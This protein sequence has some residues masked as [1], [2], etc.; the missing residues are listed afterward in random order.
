MAVRTAHLT[1]FNLLLRLCS[2]LG[3]TDIQMFVSP[4]MIKVKSTRVAKSTINAADRC[5]IF[6]EPCSK[7]CSSPPLIFTVVR[8][9]LRLCAFII[10]TAIFRIVQAM[11]W[12]A[13]G[14]AHL[15]RVPFSPAAVRFSLSLSFF[16]NVHKEIVSHNF[17]PCK[18]DIFEATYELVED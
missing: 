6:T 3:K 13:I 16:L 18:P 8:P 2:A 14:L 11:S 5:F 12:P 1:F 17:Y 9:S 10:D 7:F 15:I 4:Y